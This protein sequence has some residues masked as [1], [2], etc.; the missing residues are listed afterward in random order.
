VALT[1]EQVEGS[2]ANSSPPSASCANC[3]SLRETPYCGHCG[4]SERGS[5]R[6]RV[7]DVFAS[8][9]EALFD[10][11]SVFPATLIGMFRNPGRLCSDYVEGKRKRYMNPFAFLVAAIGAQIVL[12]SLL[13]WVGWIE[14]ETL[15][16][17]AMPDD[18]NT[19]FV[20]AAILPMVFC[21][22]FLFAKTGR[23][24]VENYVFGLYLAG[25]LAWIEL[26]ILPLP[27]IA[28]PEWFQAILIFALWVVLTTWAGANFYR[29]PWF[30]VLWRMATSTIASVILVGAVFVLVLMGVEWLGL[31]PTE[32]LDIPARDG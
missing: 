27:S 7:K 20:L 13:T 8:F 32:P 29:L 6:L 2:K 14:D 23:N 3:G 25:L 31:L 10:A 18:A 12:S 22:S 19:W 24:F 11:E 30:S 17:N 16:G 15:E 21:W 26:I 5:R 1:V 4:Q 28:M 9:A